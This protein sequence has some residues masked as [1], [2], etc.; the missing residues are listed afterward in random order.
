AAGARLEAWRT[1]LLTA[2]AHAALGDMAA[3]QL[4]V[5]HVVEEARTGGAELV[6]SSAADLAVGLGLPALPEAPA[7]DRI[8]LP[9]HVSVDAAT[10]TE[11]MVTVMFA[12]IRDYSTMAAANAPAE[13]TERVATFHRWAAR[14]VDRHRGIVDK[15]AG[16]AVMATFNV[17]EPKL[18]HCIEALGA[19]MALQDR[20]AL[21]GL[22]IG[23]GIAVGPAV[24]G[25]L[26]RD[27]NLSVLGET[28]NLASRL[29]A[30]AGVGEILLSDEAFRRAQSW[31]AERRV[32]VEHLSLELKGIPTAVPAHRVCVRHGQAMAG[33][34]GG[35]PS[36][37]A[38]F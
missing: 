38:R 30:Q 12:D 6:V 37:R 5:E 31:L 25:R 20:S 33:H 4:V 34:H 13:L 27:A 9:D 36:Q 22:Q 2:R 29:Q 1:L 23:V 28:T 21:V 17:S 18:D 16:D 11:R 15:F 26:T 8:A 24:V 10:P 14:E 3:A 19:A 32:D 35:A 7:E